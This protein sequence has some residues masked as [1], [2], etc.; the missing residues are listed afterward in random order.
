MKL[1][2]KK[3][4]VMRQ[5]LILL[6]IIV[7]FPVY[8]QSKLKPWQ[9][10][11]K[12][13]QVVRGGYLPDLP[14]TIKPEIFPMYPKGIDGIRED[15]IKN[16]KYPKKA[17]KNKVQGKVILKFAIDT[18]GTI[19]NIEVIK[20]VSKELDAEAK[21]IIKKL[22]IWLPG[23]RKGKPVRVEYRLPVNFKLS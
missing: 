5:V 10:E 21:R 18:D 6:G 2:I 9:I 17:I 12:N 22:D 16:L 11:G 23:Y 7:M 8:G 13:Y 14:D 3:Y 1:I 19:Q 15:I 4:S 20:S